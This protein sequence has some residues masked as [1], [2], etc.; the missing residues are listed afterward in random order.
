[1][2]HR[3]VGRSTVPVLLARFEP[4]DIARPDLLDRATLALD[5]ARTGDD[6][7][8]LRIGS[9]DS[10]PSE[11]SR[12]QSVV[13]EGDQ[14]RPIQTVRPPARPTGSRSVKPFRLQNRMALKLARLTPTWIRAAPRLAAI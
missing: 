3:L 11:I 7:P 14:D 13:P 4:D 8:G 1:M 2:R 12:R 10:F 9:L 6:R 5:A